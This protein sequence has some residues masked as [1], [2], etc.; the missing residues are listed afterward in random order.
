MMLQSPSVA[1][2]STWFVLQ[3]SPMKIITDNAK[4]LKNSMKYDKFCHFL[5]SV[6]YL[7][8]N[9]VNNVSGNALNVSYKPKHGSRGP[10]IWS[11]PPH[12]RPRTRYFHVHVKF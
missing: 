4:M 7:S 6:T 3:I 5:Y 1:R 2:K 8:L 10:V 12:P 9:N 11:H